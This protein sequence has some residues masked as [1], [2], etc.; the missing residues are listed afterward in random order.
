MNPPRV[1]LYGV[2]H[3]ALRVELFE[4]ATLIARTNFAD[5]DDRSATIAAYRNTM[6]FVSEHGTHEDTFVNTAVESASPGLAADVVAQH[7]EIE[8]LSASL[9]EL[10]SELEASSGMAAIAAGARLHRAYSDFLAVY[11][12][13][14]KLEE[15]AVSDALWSAY[16]DEQLA[17]IRTELQASIP[18]PRFAEWFA[19]MTA[20]MN[21]QAGCLSGVV[22]RARSSRTPR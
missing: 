18:P 1:D 9:D 4:T 15:G 2:I 13:H 5:P 7:E 14:M 11:T 10:V 6:G 3:K 19:R 21:H 22:A 17:G 20:A 8:A 16:D 12:G